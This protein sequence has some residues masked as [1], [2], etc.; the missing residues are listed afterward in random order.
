[1]CVCMYVCTYVRTYICMYVC[2]NMGKR[3]LSDIYAQAQGP[4][5][6]GHIHIS[7]KS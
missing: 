2:Y 6:L 7:G 3:D 4:Q 1:M 5:A